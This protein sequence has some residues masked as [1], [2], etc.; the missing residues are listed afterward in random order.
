MSTAS[1][2]PAAGDPAVPPPRPRLVQ[3]DPGHPRDP[4]GPTDRH[5]PGTDTTDRRPGRT[6]TRLRTDTRTETR[7][8]TDTGPDRRPDRKDTIT[9]TPADITTDGGPA[10]GPDMGPDS[11][12]NGPEGRTD[13]GPV[14]APGPAP[15]TDPDAKGKNSQ[16][17]RLVAL[18]VGRY[19][20]VN[21]EGRC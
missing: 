2:L 3:P 8:D 6:V 1:H 21:W 16:A 10:T 5:H 12:D 14:T 9:D 19:N 17:S 20:L 18:A 15:D 11:A 13:T 7:T 4:T